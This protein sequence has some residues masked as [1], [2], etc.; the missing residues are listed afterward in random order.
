MPPVEASSSPTVTELL[1]GDPGPRLPVPVV[2]RRTWRVPDSESLAGRPNRKI[3][4]LA[5]THAMVPPAQ[6]VENCPTNGEVAAAYEL[7]RTQVPGQRVLRPRNV[8][9]APGRIELLIG[10]VAADEIGGLQGAD[11]RLEP[12]RRDPVVGI[13]ARE[14]NTTSSSNSQIPC[15][16]HRPGCV[17]AVHKPNR[18]Q[19]GPPALDPG[20]RIVG[21]AV[22]N[23]HQFPAAAVGLGGQG[24]ELRLNRRRRV[25]H[26]QDHRNHLVRGTAVRRPRTV[27]SRYHHALSRRVLVYLLDALEPD[28]LERWSDEG[29]LP[30]IA[31]L[32]RSAREFRVQNRVDFL[33]DSIFGELLTGRSV[34]R[35]GDLTVLEHLHSGEATAREPTFAELHARP[36]FWRAACR[37]GHRALLVDLP[38][39]T[40]DREIEGFQL[41]E[42]GMHYARSSPAT[43]PPGRLN[44]IL[45]E[46]GPYPVVNG[47]LYPPRLGDLT[48]LR[49]DLL[50]GVEIKER[51]FRSFLETEDWDLAILTASEAHVAGHRFWHLWEDGHPLQPPGVGDRHKSYLREIYQAI[52]RSLETALDRAGDDTEVLVLAT[53]GF[54]RFGGAQEMMAEFCERLGLGS[55]RTLRLKLS[56]LAPRSLKRAIRHV[57]PQDTMD[58]FGLGHHA[59]MRGFAGA[60]VQAIAI[61]N[62]RIGA[63]RLNLGGREPEGRVQPGAEAEGILTRIEDEVR[64]LRDVRTGLPVVQSVTRAS[65]AFGSDYHPNLPDLLVDFRHDIGPIDS[66]ESKTVGRLHR[67]KVH[68]RTGDHTSNSRLWM[69]RTGA[70]DPAS[71]SAAAGAGA[72]L[73]EDIDILDIAPTVLSRLGVEL[74]DGLDGR[75]IEPAPVP[76]R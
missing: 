4:V 68:F 41:Q 3:D 59:R 58:R 32:R 27:S 48:R 69:L 53:H 23:D 72:N 36:Y 21:R 26:W 43:V 51:L 7:E 24:L 34:V 50:R 52:D 49:D 8:P 55:G 1:P 10:K 13:T 62:Q 46:Y 9:T 38:G 76:G 60:E 22:V 18:R 28:L 74:P 40:I 64:Q 5:W 15:R 2:N 63:F 20:H 56:V 33:P 29:Y 47:D 11:Q 31:R 37:Q 14:Q 42:Y 75:P 57:L 70:N 45:D 39:G 25:E 17:R 12:S 61:P 67:P 35:T 71:A 73:V 30:Q 65:E 44:A 54:Q 16:R 6:L 19:P 66:I